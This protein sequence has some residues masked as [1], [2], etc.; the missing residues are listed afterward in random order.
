M[1]P[2]MFVRHRLCMSRLQDIESGRAY[3]QVIGDIT[4][5]LNPKK[6]KPVVFRS[7]KVYYDL[8]AAREEKKII[9]IAIVRL[10]QFYPFPAKP[11]AKELGRYPKAEVIWCQEEPQNMVAW[12]FLDRRLEAVLV[13]ADGKCKRPIYSGR[14]ESASPA[15]GSLKKHNKE[16]AELMDKTLTAS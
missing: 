12:H 15:A 4:A 11:L 14:P 10:E 8:L 16:Q 9:D 2:K 1:T 13:E 7:G 5:A 6:I 3:E